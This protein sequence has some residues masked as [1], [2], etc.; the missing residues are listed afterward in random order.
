MAGFNYPANVAVDANGTVFV[1][2]ANNHRIRKVS[3]GGGT[4]IRPIT[5]HSAR[6]IAAVA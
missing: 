5:L 6:L 2:D 3:A 1:A 4:R